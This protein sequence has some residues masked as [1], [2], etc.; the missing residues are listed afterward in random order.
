MVQPKSYCIRCIMLDMNK[1]DRK[2]I[3]GPLQRDLALHIDL[4]L[5]KT[6]FDDSRLQEM[7]V[8]CGCQQKPSGRLVLEED[9]YETST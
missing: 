6:K 2:V 8:L 9:L 7:K 1:E 3:S 4:D 5:E